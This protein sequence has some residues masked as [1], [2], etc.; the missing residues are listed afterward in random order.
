MQTWY[1]RKWDFATTNVVDSLRIE[2]VTVSEDKVGIC[3]V[4]K[5]KKRCGESLRVSIWISLITIT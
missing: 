2:V 5:V 4:F 1:V 3:S